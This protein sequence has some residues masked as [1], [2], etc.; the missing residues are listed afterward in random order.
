MGIA[1][2]YLMGRK[3]FARVDGRTPTG[4]TEG[5][6]RA[7]D[8]G[9]VGRRR[10]PVSKS[11]T[12]AHLFRPPRFNQPTPAPA[13]TAKTNFFPGRTDDGYKMNRRGRNGTRKVSHNWPFLLEQAAHVGALQAPSSSSSFSSFSSCPSQSVGPISQ[14]RSSPPPPC[15]FRRRR[16]PLLF[17]PRLLGRKSDWAPRIVVDHA[18]LDVGSST[19]SQSVARSSQHFKWDVYDTSAKCLPV[20]MAWAMHMIHTR[21]CPF[22]EDST[23]GRR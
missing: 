18:F 14:Y 13:R 1:K 21:I 19:L 20:K 8:G 10:R 12:S 9:G 7:R 16:L 11:D 6:R 2:G 23:Q 17:L 15:Y 5:G 3:G 22:I 4:G